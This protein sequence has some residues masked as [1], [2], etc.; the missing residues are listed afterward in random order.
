MDSNFRLKLLNRRLQN[1]LGFVYIL[2][3]VLGFYNK[4]EVGKLDRA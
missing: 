2:T 3:Q 1:E 4:A